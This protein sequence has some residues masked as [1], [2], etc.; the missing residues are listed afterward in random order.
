M[1]PP[2]PVVEEDS[3]SPHVLQGP[4]KDYSL[5]DNQTFTISIPGRSGKSDSGLNLPG[6]SGMISTDHNISSSKGSIPLLPPPPSA[7]KRRWVPMANNANMNL[8]DYQTALFSFLNPFLCAL[9]YGAPCS[10]SYVYTCLYKLF[11]T[12]FYNGVFVGV[13]HS[14]IVRCV[15]WAFGWHGKSCNKKGKQAHVRSWMGFAAWTL[16]F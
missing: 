2:T 6:S 11:C 4:K 9:G 3:P 12:G 1:N 8:L 14:A 7:P 15:L 13:W 16:L 10:T 5:K